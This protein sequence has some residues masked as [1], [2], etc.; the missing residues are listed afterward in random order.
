MSSPHSLFQRKNVCLIDIL[1]NTSVQ[2][3]CET[4]SFVNR[5]LKMQS[6]SPD[7][8]DRAS[9]CSVMTDVR[10]L[11]V[12]LFCEILV[13]WSIT[14]RLSKRSTLRLS[15]SRANMEKKEKN[16]PSDSST[17]VVGVCMCYLFISTRIHAHPWLLQCNLPSSCTWWW[18]TWY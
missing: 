15:R 1:R 8:N 3:S 16:I 18:Q 5:N 4:L 6:R 12:C 7:Q 13:T 2:I 10:I 17:K 14:K 9:C 11:T